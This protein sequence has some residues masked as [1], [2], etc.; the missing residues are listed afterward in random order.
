[1]SIGISQTQTIAEQEV[2]LPFGR[3]YSRP[4]HS[5]SR[6]T[7]SWPP[8]AAISRLSKSSS[9]LGVHERLTGTH[10]ISYVPPFI[11]AGDFDREH[12]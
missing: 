9:I 11:A 3:R 8:R 4:S 7:Y 1:M 10:R 5:Q 2:R 12:L 6:R